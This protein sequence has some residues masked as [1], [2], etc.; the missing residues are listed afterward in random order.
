MGK[1]NK[2][3]SRKYGLPPGSL[4]HVREKK[5]EQVSIDFMDY[6]EENFD[7]KTHIL[8]CIARQ[9]QEVHR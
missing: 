7:E 1:L 3:I 9:K 6:N 4:I 2:R 5:T 8:L